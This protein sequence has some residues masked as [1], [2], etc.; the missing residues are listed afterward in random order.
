M[1]PSVCPHTPPASFIAFHCRALV[2]TNAA[3]PEW[4]EDATVVALWRHART[5]GVR[6]ENHWVQRLRL[7]LSPRSTPHPLPLRSPNGQQYSSSGLELAYFGAA[8][9][10]TLP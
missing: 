2:L 1:N 6:G 5:N 3:L 8:Q 9:S 10:S 4:E 7:Q